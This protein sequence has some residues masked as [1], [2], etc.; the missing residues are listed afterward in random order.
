MQSRAADQNKPE[1]RR[2]REKSISAG[3]TD[4]QMKKDRYEE[5]EDNDTKQMETNRL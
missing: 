2:N 3:Q 4:I 5:Y 1:T